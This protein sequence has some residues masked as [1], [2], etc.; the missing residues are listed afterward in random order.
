MTTAVED[1]EKA[2]AQLSPQEL[3]RFRIWFDAA[4][5]RDVRDGKLDAMAQEAIAAYRVNCNRSQRFP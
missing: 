5:E 3:A 4:I 2:V 1:I